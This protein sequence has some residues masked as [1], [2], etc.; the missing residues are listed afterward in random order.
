MSHYPAVHYQFPSSHET[1]HIVSHY[2]PVCRSDAASVQTS[3]EFT[4]DMDDLFFWIDETENILTSFVSMQEEALD[5]VLEKIKV[6]VCPSRVH[7]SVRQSRVHLSMQEEALDEVLEKIKVIVCP[8]DSCPSV[9]LSFL[10]RRDGEHPDQL[11]V[12]AGGGAG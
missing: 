8:S 9:C 6:I 5:E 1:W 2:P 10:D 11:R 3:S 7:L 4:E 12:H